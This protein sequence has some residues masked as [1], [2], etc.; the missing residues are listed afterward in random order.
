MNSVR[1]ASAFAVDASPRKDEVNRDRRALFAPSSNRGVSTPAPRDALRRSRGATPRGVTCPGENERNVDDD[2]DD[3]DGEG[4]GE[5]SAR[6]SGRVIPHAPH[7]RA[8][9]GLSRVHV[10]H[11]QCFVEI[12]SEGWAGVRGG[13]AARPGP[14]RADVDGD[15]RRRR[16]CR[17]EISSDRSRRPRPAL[18]R[19]LGPLS[20]LSM[21]PVAPDPSTCHLPRPSMRRFTCGGGRCEMTLASARVQMHEP[22]EHLGRLENLR[23][24]A[25]EE[26]ELVDAHR[27]LAHVARH[28]LNLLLE[29]GGFAHHRRVVRLDSRAHRKLHRLLLG[30]KIV[31]RAVG[32]EGGARIA[33]VNSCLSNEPSPSRSKRR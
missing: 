33:F 10:S 27:A 8:T 22:I 24:S 13:F 3:D 4:K 31:L 30:A 11:A 20:D 28:S 6:L 23:E 5:S 16:R 14:A 29:R 17:V 15:A 2:G 9:A 25:D 26:P 7:R 18:T 1:D 12:V 19:Y 32:V 21:N